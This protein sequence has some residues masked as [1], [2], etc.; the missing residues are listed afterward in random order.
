MVIKC[1]N[2][3]HY[4]SDTASVCPKCGA[5]MTVSTPKNLANDVTDTN[6][7]S[8]SPKTFNSNI[9]VFPELAQYLRQHL[10]L[11]KENPDISYRTVINVDDSIVNIYTKGNCYWED[12]QPI[13]LGGYD[14]GFC[15]YLDFIIYAD[16]DDE[17]NKEENKIE[18]DRIQRLRNLAFFS[19]FIP[20]KTYDSDGDCH[21]EYAIDIGD[22]IESASH[23]IS[24]IV[25][26][27][28]LVPLSDELDIATETIDD[29]VDDEGDAEEY[30]E[31][32]QTVIDTSKENKS[33][34]WA[35]YGAGIGAAIVYLIIKSCS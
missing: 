32:S 19:Q 18:N 29:I 13:R 3:N 11:Q 23:I 4:V 24:E 25:Q 1:P 27:V 5:S 9:E 12:E 35:G 8:E 6:N 28:Y 16:E 22:D 14:N 33:Q 31:S 21:R 34:K 15:L 2:C 7:H 30:V 10:I 20:H 26:I 17:D